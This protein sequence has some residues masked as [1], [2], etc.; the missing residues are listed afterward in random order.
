MPSEELWIVPISM[1]SYLYIY[2]GYII[3]VR[4]KYVHI[5]IYTHQG[6]AL[7]AKHFPYCIFFQKDRI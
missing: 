1:G 7:E 3:Y 5:Y 6:Y 2:Q 4:D